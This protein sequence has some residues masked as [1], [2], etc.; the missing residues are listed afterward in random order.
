[1]STSWQ[2]HLTLLLLCIL[3]I[4]PGDAFSS[5]V[6]LATRAYGDLYH[7]GRGDSVPVYS[8]SSSITSPVSVKSFHSLPELNYSPPRPKSPI[9]E[10]RRRR[11]SRN[12]IQKVM[13]RIAPPSPDPSSPGGPLHHVVVGTPIPDW[14]PPLS[15][16][17]WLKPSPPPPA[18]P[19][20]VQKKESLWTKVRGAAKKAGR[21]MSCA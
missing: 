14:S 19:K 12:R 5:T 15:T 1:M 4:L 9:R 20:L 21:C 6:W 3:G 13:H 2:W 16:P 8:P 17:S 7:A 18:S 11:R 10:A